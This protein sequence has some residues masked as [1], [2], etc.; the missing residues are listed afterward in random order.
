MLL[1]CGGHAVEKGKC[2]GAP[3]DGFRDGE[4]GCGGAGLIEQCG[5]KVDGREVASGGDAALG[6]DGLDAVA[7]CRLRQPNDIDEPADCAVWKSQGWE[8]E[9]GEVFEECVVA[10][11]GGLA[12][13]E[14]FFNAAELDAAEGTGDV[15]EA[16]VVAGFGVVE[17][18]GAWLPTLIS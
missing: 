11:G 5:L 16:V 15:G 13:C 7:V 2:K 14:H 17:P 3:G 6:E 18:I 9:G 12:E 1:L 8:F 10:Q 4:M